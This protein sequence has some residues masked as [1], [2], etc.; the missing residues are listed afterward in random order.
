MASIVVKL[1]DNPD[2]R[3]QVHICRDG[4]WSPH[5]NYSWDELKA[6]ALA[7]LRRIEEPGSQDMVRLLEDICEV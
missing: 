4:F 1:M 3:I 6:I 7:V 2:G 5:I